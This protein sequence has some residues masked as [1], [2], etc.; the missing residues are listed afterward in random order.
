MPISLTT[1]WCIVGVTMVNSIT[2]THPTMGT[3]TPARNDQAAPSDG[4]SGERQPVGNPK[5]P[6]IERRK[7]QDR[8]SRQ[9]SK[10]PVYDMRISKK[11]R[12]KTDR[13]GIPSIETEA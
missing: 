2:P 8:R 13:G 4:I 10:R 5:K 12:R 9:G 1:S 7:N 11:G 6:F 3:K